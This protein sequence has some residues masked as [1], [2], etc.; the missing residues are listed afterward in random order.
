MLHLAGAF[1][2]AGHPVDLVLCRAEGPYM[3]EVPPG[4]RIVELHRQSGLS[5]RLQIAR[6]DPDGMAALARPV[7]FPCRP[8]PVQPYLSSLARYLATE[9]P[10]ALLAGKTPTN[11]LALWASRLSGADTRIVISEHTQLSQSIT[12]SRKWRWR[13]IAPVVAR[14]YPE[15]AAIV[16]VS[17][18]VADDLATTAGLPRDGISTIYNPVVTPSLA[19]QAS[20]P[21]PHP[22]LEDGGAPVIVA[23]GRLTPQKN[24]PL[25][26]RAFARLRERHPARLLLLGE[27][28]ERARLESLASTLGISGDVALPGFI[29]NPYAAFSRAAL[30]VMSSDYEGLGNVLIEALACGCPVV[31]TDCPSGPSEILENGRY[32]ELVPVNDSETLAAAMLRTL[33]APLARNKL[34]QRGAEFSLERS[35]GH[36]L[37][38][39]MPSAFTS[40]KC[41]R[42]AS[43]KTK[44]VMSR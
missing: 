5:A 10:A 6:L 31:S 23:A 1:H 35:A 20:E 34:R 13:H 14:T 19:V 8:A 18:G 7:L 2:A 37:K 25:L 30:F 27:G 9:R 41:N 44:L 17:N 11:L 32:G 3:S 16:A 21:A 36:Y 33:E 40:K 22:W 28:P 42:T 26:M 39:L 24:F 4:V 43:P 15:A 12:L 38:L 29:G